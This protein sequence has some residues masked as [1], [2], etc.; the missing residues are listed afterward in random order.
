MKR[1]G[2]VLGANMDPQTKTSVLDPLI[3]RTLSQYRI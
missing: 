3:G 1:G 2:V